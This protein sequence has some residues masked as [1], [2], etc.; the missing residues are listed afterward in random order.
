MAKKIPKPHDLFLHAT[1][2]SPQAIHDLFQA[3]LPEQLRKRTQINSIVPTQPDHIS[4]ALKELHSDFIFTCQIDGHIGFICLEHQSTPDW[5]MPLRF[6]DYNTHLT[7]QY[8][9]G[10]EAGTR[11]PFIVN[12]C[13]YHYTLNEPYPYPTNLYDYF[14]DPSLAKELDMF[15]KFQVLNLSNTP[16]IELES[17][18][19]MGLS[20][21]LF[22]YTREKVFFEVL[23]QELERCRKWILGEGMPIAPLGAN[24]WESIFYY[25]IN[26]LDPEE[27]SQENVISLFKEALC[28]NK[29]NVMKTIARQIEKIG[30]KRGLL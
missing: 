24:Y 30:E 3:H 22:K 1:L 5:S 29:D 6:L 19:T 2:S 25:A 8:L 27:Y 9:K 16:D 18:G 12:L 10:K 15:T 11:L 14:P 4:P 21:K 7:K 20:E 26:V 28:I 23:G 17:Y 13:L